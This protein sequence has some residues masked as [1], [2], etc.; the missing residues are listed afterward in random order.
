MSE[1]CSGYQN[2]L[3]EAHQRKRKWAKCLYCDTRAYRTK[4]STDDNQTGYPVVPE[5][6]AACLNDL[7]GNADPTKT[8]LFLAL[9]K[10]H[11]FPNGI[12]MQCPVEGCQNSI[13]GD[14]VIIGDNRCGDFD[15]GAK[16]LSSCN[17]AVPGACQEIGICLL[18]TQ[19][20]LQRKG[21]GSYPGKENYLAL[22][23]RTIT[24]AFADGC[25]PLTFKSTKSD[26]K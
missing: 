12:S 20:R 26:F 13:H 2:A 23:A 8:C 14:E 19:L 5:G 22:L 10:K 25:K 21:E 24:T 9:L 6:G 16:D 11:S 1:Y 17:H 4:E 3:K 7:E 15:F 18:E